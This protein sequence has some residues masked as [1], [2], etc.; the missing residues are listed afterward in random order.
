VA[1]TPS[2]EA[3]FKAAVIGD[4]E[5]IV[6]FRGLGFHVVHATG[7]EEVINAIRSL[8]KSGEYALVIVLKNAVEEE[9][10]VKDEARR[11]GL[12]I[13]VLPTRKAP[14]KPIDINKLIARALGFG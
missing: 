12:P 7:D 14:S 10:R 9:N 13:L 1:Q 4:K 11:L 6:L 5:T 2:S 3:F 8:A